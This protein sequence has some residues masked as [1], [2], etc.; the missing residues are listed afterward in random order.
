MADI[1]CSVRVLPSLPANCGQGNK[2]SVGVVQKSEA[3]ETLRPIPPLPPIKQPPPRIAPKPI[4]GRTIRPVHPTLAPPSTSPPPAIK[5]QPPR[6]APK[7]I[8][9]R[10][11]HPGDPT[12]AQQ[13]TQTLAPP[14]AP[15]LVPA[16]TSPQAPIKHLPPRIAPKPIHGRPTPPVDSAPAAP[17]SLALGEPDRCKPQAP[18]KSWLKPR[19]LAQS[20]DSPVF[21]PSHPSLDE[22]DKHE[23][24]IPLRIPSPPAIPL[25]TRLLGV[26]VDPE[27]E[28]ASR[29]KPPPPPKNPPPPRSSLNPRR[30]R[31]PVDPSLE[32]PNISIPPPPPP[33]HLPSLRGSLKPSQLPHPVEPPRV[34]SSFLQ[35]EEPDRHQPTIT[36]R[37]GSLQ[38]HRLP[39][40][41]DPPRVP[42]SHP[43]FEEPDLPKPPAPKPRTVRPVA[44]SP[45]VAP[46]YRVLSPIIEH[47]YESD[48]VVDLSADNFE[49]FTQSMGKVLVLFFNSGQFNNEE[50]RNEFALAADMNR[51]REGNFGAVDCSE[52]RELCYREG[53]CC[54]PML[55]LFSDGFVMSSIKQPLCFKASQMQVLINTV[56]GMIFKPVPNVEKKDSHRKRDIFARILRRK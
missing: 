41:V 20:A 23:P 10:P 7:P 37:I 8:H 31:Q 13:S 2:R 35:L 22:P 47:T 17:Y 9:G 53:A 43:A 5:H 15:P 33:K 32:Y 52:D 44:P 6:V 29:L 55:K 50:L 14:S 56:P 40:S 51:E 11:T 49:Q 42:S 30:K 24:R 46:R 1:K 12:I 27:V 45:P 54:T 28:E 39:H 38:Q 4:Q 36:P 26:S 48:K 18:T 21:L 16:S 19:G 25:R 3:Q 34:P